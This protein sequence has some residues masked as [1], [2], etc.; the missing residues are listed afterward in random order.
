M[1]S[2][3]KILVRPFGSGKADRLAKKADEGH[4]FIEVVDLSPLHGSFQK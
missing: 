2:I 1:H 3:G 4:G